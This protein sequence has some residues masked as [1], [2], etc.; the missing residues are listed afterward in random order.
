MIV[1]GKNVFNDIDLKKIRRVFLSSNFH[2]KDVMSRIQSNGIKYLVREQKELDRMSLHNQ[3][4][5][6]EINDYDYK[7]IAEVTGNLVVMLDH[8]EDP[9]NFGAIIRTCEAAGI[10]SII[11]PKDR[12]VVVN[13]TVM[14]TSAGT[15]DRV[16][17]IQVT[18]LVNAINK[19]KDKGYFIYGADMN[20]VNYKDASYADKNVLVIGN[21]G[22]G[23]SKIVRDNLDE[24]ISIPM[25][26]SVNSLNASVAAAILIYGIGE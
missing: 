20:G 7:T 1:S 23:I 21:E 5:V 15:L 10:K 11:I 6:I 14:K 18:N 25:K 3:G 16:D 17:I 26:G 19:L 24:V 12:S 4:I 9:H 22:K 2:D 13:D 8:I